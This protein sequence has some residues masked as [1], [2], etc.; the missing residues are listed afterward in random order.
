MSDV[1]E[2]IHEHNLSRLEGAGELAYEN[3]VTFSKVLDYSYEQSRHMVS[4]T[5]SLGVREVTSRSGQAGIPLA[6]AQAGGTN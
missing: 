2:R 4:L 5:E 6:G 1:P 3:M